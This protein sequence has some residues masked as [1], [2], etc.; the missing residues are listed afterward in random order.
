MWFKVDDKLHDH[1]KVHDVLI[2][3]DDPL[4]GL[5]AMGLWVLAGSW[6][7]DQLADGLVPA[8]ILR[9]WGPGVSTELTDLLTRAGLW[10]PATT[11]NGRAAITFHDWL[12]FNDSREKVEADRLAAKIR[13][14]FYRDKP[15]K[16][17]ID[18]RDKD[19][20]RYC[21]TLV[22]W[23]DKRGRGGGTYDH[24]K[25]IKHGGKNTLENVV[26][27][28]RACNGRKG[29]LTLS[30]AGMRLLTP[31]SL[32]A[33]VLDEDPDDPELYLDREGSASGRVGSGRVAG[34]VLGD[35]EQQTGTT[36]SPAS[37][38]S[39]P[40]SPDPQANQA[41]GGAQ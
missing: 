34:N 37:Q 26:V 17:A 10:D 18:R 36:T 1:E 39:S 4:L 15:L 16:A 14:A 11:D 28:C 32:G 12:E 38:T 22:N 31:G 30:E 40:A 7:G 8:H 2:E 5:A 24:I 21:G 41:D 35:T 20:C 19:R 3:A 13:Q 29:E 25:P 23:S 27:C 33:P 9:R 6:S